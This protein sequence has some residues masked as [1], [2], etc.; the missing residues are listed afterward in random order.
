MPRFYFR[1]VDSVNTEVKEEG[2]QLPD[3]QAAWVEAT[4]A[5]GELLKELDGAL[6]PGDNWQ[7]QVKDQAG[8]ILYELEFRTRKF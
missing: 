4:A 7:M 6:K 1:I 8:R 3:K 2:L 5:C